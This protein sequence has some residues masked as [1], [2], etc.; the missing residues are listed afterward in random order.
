VLV[1]VKS[2]DD[3]SDFDYVVVYGVGDEQVMVMN[4]VVVD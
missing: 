4:V 3:H 1:L 2:I